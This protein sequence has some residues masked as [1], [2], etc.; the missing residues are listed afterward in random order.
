MAASDKQMKINLVFIVNPLGA[1][2][3]GTRHKRHC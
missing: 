1:M 2:A 3:Q